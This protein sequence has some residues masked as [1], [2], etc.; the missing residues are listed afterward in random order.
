MKNE[1]EYVKTLKEWLGEEN[2]RYF[3]HLKGLKGDVFPVLKLNV[4]TKGLPIYPV[5]FREGRNIRNF[6]NGKF[7]NMVSELGGYD[8]FED[9]VHELMNKVIQ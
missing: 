6:L 4:R 7:P 5:H 9:Y 2:I 3:R 1:I 8:K